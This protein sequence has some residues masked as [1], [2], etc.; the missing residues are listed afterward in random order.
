MQLN[1]MIDRTYMYVQPASCTEDET[2]LCSCNARLIDSS[3][4]DQFS[5]RL[6]LIMTPPHK[7]FKFRPL[8]YSCVTR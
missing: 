5:S 4:L 6:Q 8:V 3:F 7:K 2:N 1:I